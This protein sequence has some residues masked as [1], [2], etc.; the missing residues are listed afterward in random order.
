MPPS[1]HYGRHV[2]D[3][4]RL[5]AVLAVALAGCSFDGVVAESYGPAPDAAAVDHD[6]EE[7]SAADASTLV[8]R[9]G[10][11][12]LLRDGFDD[13]TPAPF[14]YR[15]SDPGVTVVETAGHVAIQLVAGTDDAAYGGYDSNFNYD[16]TGG[17][18][19]ATVTQVGGDYTTLEL[20][21][22][23]GRRIQMLVA[24]RN[25]LIGKV[26]DVPDPAPETEIAY[27]PVAHRHWRIRE[28]GG[29]L[30]W[31]TSPDRVVWAE[32]RREPVPYP[33]DHV[34]GSIV[35]GGLVTGVA[36][37]ARFEDVGAEVAGAETFCPLET[38]VDDFAAAPFL[39]GWNSWSN[40]NCTV[41]ESGGQVALGFTGV[42]ET[43]CGIDSR[44]LFDLRGSG[45]YADVADAAAVQRFVSFF[46][47]VPT[48]AADSRL[49]IARNNG[50]LRFIQRVAGI[51][52]DDV[53]VA[54]D[55]VAHRYWRIAEDAGTL[56]WQTS[57]DATT[58]VTR[59]QATADFDVDV[60]HVVAGAGSYETGPG[61][62]I[63]IG[64]RSLNAP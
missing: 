28:A 53:G 51:N 24:D 60:M 29:L 38:L 9:C 35:A 33:L 6:A 55:P 64:Y 1:R 22:L 11:I 23:A 62:P 4:L 26:L 10:T 34:R 47:A 50:Q 12:S 42:G 14:F 46:Q 58:W 54:Y 32:L 20:Q 27:D 15:W 30:F 59:H 25:M 36:T 3:R 21:D 43:F 13:A 31:E 18:F 63:S 7:E 56:L 19:S 57:P 39:P 17:A 5:A 8:A 37:E 52:V 41:V 48:G 49:E 44:H 45:V 16:M 40:G 61:S 2:H